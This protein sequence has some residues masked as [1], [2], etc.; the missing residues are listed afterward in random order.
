M[1]SFHVGQLRNLLENNSLARSLID[2]GDAKGNTPLHVL[3]AVRPKEFHVLKSQRIACQ[4]E[5]AKL[6]GLPN[7]KKQSWSAKQFQ[8]TKLGV[9]KL[10]HAIPDPAQ[11][12]DKL[13]PTWSRMHSINR[14]AFCNCKYPN[15][16][17]VESNCKSCSISNC[18]THVSATSGIKADGSY[19]GGYGTIHVY[20]TVHESS[21]NKGDKS[22]RIL[23]FNWD[24]VPVQSPGNF[25]GAFIHAK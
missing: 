2:E 8:K 13:N 15:L 14:E 16:R 5:K 24:R 12:F 25:P 17:E 23:V 19:L 10:V 3:A 11:R 20:G 18:S 22:L 21:V 7:S 6:V 1:V 9:E 4:I